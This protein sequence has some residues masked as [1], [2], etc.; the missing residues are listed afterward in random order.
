MQLAR[1]L[2]DA[3]TSFSQFPDRDLGKQSVEVRDWDG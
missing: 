1:Y 3:G 2:H